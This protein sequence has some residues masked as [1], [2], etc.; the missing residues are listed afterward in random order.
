MPI[1]YSGQTEKNQMRLKFIVKQAECSYL[2]NEE[3]HKK[4]WL[5]ILM[6]SAAKAL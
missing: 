3:I 5:K 1:H 6:T 4:H 2:S